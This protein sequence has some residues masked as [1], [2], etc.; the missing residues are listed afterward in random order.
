M[1]EAFFHLIGSNGFHVKAG[2]LSFTAAGSRCRQN[3]KF[4]NFTSSFWS[5]KICLNAI[6]FP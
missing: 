6:I 2:N 5:Q 4:E 3:L 1:G